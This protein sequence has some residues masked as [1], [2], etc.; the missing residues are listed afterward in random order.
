MN[1]EP[2]PMIVFVAYISSFAGLIMAASVGYLLEGIVLQSIALVLFIYSL[3]I[4]NKE[5]NEK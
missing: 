2:I 4:I 3:I 5:K 1:K